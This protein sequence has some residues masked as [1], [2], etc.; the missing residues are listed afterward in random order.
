MFAD[1]A[2]VAALADEDEA[3]GATVVVVAAAEP[4]P[5]LEAPVLDAPVLDAAVTGVVVAVAA[6]VAAVDD[7]PLPAMHAASPATPTTLTTPVTMRAFRA[8]WV[9]RRRR[10]GAGI[11]CIS[12]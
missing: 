10:A 9:R 6:D 8:G 3:R 5:V 11:D 12:Q 1:A 2:G 7:E 4:D